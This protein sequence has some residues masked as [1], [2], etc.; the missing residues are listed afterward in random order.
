MDATR[1]S[2]LARV[3]STAI[4]ASAGLSTASL[5]EE[6]TPAESGGSSMV[7][8]SDSQSDV[9]DRY[10]H[11]TTDLP[12][13]AEGTLEVVTPAEE[14]REPLAEPV[15][16][17]G[18]WNSLRS[19]NTPSDAVE[20]KH[21]QPS[22][23]LARGDLT[24][25]SN[26]QR[27]VSL[28]AGSERLAVITTQPNVRRPL[29]SASQL[30]KTGDKKQ[31]DGVQLA[32]HEVMATDRP[33]TD[34]IA[35]LLLLANKLSKQANTAGDYT[36]VLEACR[37]AIRQGAQ[38]ERRA[39]AR[40]L[41]S[42]ALNR[43]GQLHVGDG[44]RDLATSDFS[45]ALEY[46]PRNWHAVHNRGVSY[47]QSGQLAEAFDDFNQ[48]IVLNPEHAKAHC[49]RAT[50]F[51]QAKDLASALE[52]YLQAK[53]LNSKLVTAHVGLGRACHSLGRREEAISHFDEAIR[54]EPEN[55]DTICS[56]ADL[57]A[58]MGRYGDAL[59]DY[60]HTI[61][62][63][64]KFAHAYRNGAW[65]LATCPR[66][67]YRDAE[68][69]VLGA[70]QALE[71]NYGQRHVALDTLAAALANAGQ[72]KEAVTTVKRAIDLAP[73]DARFA[74]LARLQLYQDGEPF[75]T[76]PVGT[77]SQVIYETSDH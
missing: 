61:E 62:L 22:P 18:T 51:V 20:T 4:I 68:N 8:V 14:K 47:A 63:D 39:F 10:A 46:N 66:E 16:Q 26:I 29:S 24:V 48:A 7:F 3:F 67:Q 53:Q 34:P 12:P 64:P 44:L 72:F 30:G 42:W 69:A 40:Q 70:R 58:D 28:R 27:Q 73:G 23:R 32:S 33:S 71:S 41:S 6:E 15:V 38:G 21:F 1:F 57:L 5:A 17:A 74:Y 75:R 11:V 76:Q 45:A 35:T 9:E 13:S 37:G 52:D 2:L 43:R 65:L 60:A 59:D 50:L 19:G 77:V 55:V 49:N 56:R 25:V 31:S 54:L 36:K